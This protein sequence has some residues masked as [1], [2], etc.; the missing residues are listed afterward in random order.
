MSPSSSSSGVLFRRPSSRH[1]PSR[2]STATMPNRSMVDSFTKH[3]ASYYYYSPKAK[4]KKKQQ[5]HFQ[6]PDCSGTSTH[7]HI[8]THVHTNNTQHS[9]T[10]YFHFC[11]RKFTALLLLIIH[12][13]LFNLYTLH[14]FY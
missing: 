1:Q 12:K 4:Q 3:K 5:M 9:Q 7:I 2:L 11:R 14:T 6:A 10:L 8:H 13:I